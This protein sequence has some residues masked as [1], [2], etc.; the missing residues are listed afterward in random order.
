MATF[1]TVELS[2]T[3]AAASAAFMSE[4]FDYGN[5]FYGDAYVDVHAND[6][7]TVAFETVADQ[8]VRPPLAIFQVDDLDATQ[9]AVVAAGGAITVEQF[10][11]PGG[12]RFQFREPGGNELSAWVAAAH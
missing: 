10:D 11:F 12:R 7:F 3:D 8:E 9:A 1:T 4:V 2:S 5:T 6:G